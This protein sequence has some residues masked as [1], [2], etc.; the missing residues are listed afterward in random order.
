MYSVEEAVGNET[1]QKSRRPRENT[2][3]VCLRFTYVKI[4]QLNIK[5]KIWFGNYDQS[6]THF[7]T[8]PI[9]DLRN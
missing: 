9:T 1:K 2:F 8:P 5:M 6:I 7:K 3:V 4:D